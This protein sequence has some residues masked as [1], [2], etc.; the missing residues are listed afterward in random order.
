MQHGDRIR[1]GH[2]FYFNTMSYLARRTRW[3]P[4]LGL[5]KSSTWWEKTPS[6]MTSIIVNVIFSNARAH[7][8]IKR[9]VQTNLGS[10]H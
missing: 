8:R 1:W 5:R 2:I 3:L 10:Q 7:A 4:P 6:E 9:I